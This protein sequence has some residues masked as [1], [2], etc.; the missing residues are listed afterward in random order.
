M[1]GVSSR[2]ASIPLPGEEHASVPER[3]LGRHARF[4]RAHPPDARVLPHRLLPDR[5]PVVR[6]RGIDPGAAFRSAHRHTVGEPV[7]VAGPAHY[8][9][10]G[11]AAFDIS[12]N[13]V[14]VYR[15]GSGLQA[16][17]LVLFDRHGREVRAITPDGYY[18]RPVF[19]PDGQRLA[20]ER[21]DSQ[22]GNSDVWLYDL[23]R[24]SALQ[25]TSG[26]AP[27]VRPTW[28][29][30]GRR[31]AFSSRRRDTF[32]IYVK[33]VDAADSEQLVD[34]SPGDKLVDHWSPAGT[35]LAVT[36]TR[37]GLWTFPLVPG[38]K[39]TLV[40]GSTGTDPWQSEFSPDG[41]WIAYV[42]SERPTPDVF[43][44]PVPAT[45]E[46][47][48]VS[49]Q[50]GSDPHWRGDGRELIY[51]APDGRL[52]GVSITPGPR[53]HVGA[54]YVLFRVTVP[55]L[56]GPTDVTLSREGRFIVV[57]TLL[58][59]PHVPPIHAI[60]NWTQLLSR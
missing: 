10:A 13:G 6:S 29:P 25:L 9:R 20:A 30:D 57:N 28:S 38:A 8:H 2:R 12:N 4:T 42:S 54:P 48:Q 33:T 52:L 1:A 22:F 32:D 26:D 35:T 53:W 17:R 5:S 59:A 44:E 45:G 18:K 49:A 51:L 50:G 40:R 55:E 23:A 31:I 11:D 60:V 56:L 36:V 34:A 15:P 19:S 41:R 46:R 39:P 3:P 58:E 14:L 37:S 47:W 43:V 27:D 21:Y 24:D 16:S 7:T